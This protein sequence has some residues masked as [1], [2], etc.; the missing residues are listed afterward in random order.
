MCPFLCVPVHINIYMEM[1]YNR[2]NL[3]PNPFFC[4][5]LYLMVA[6]GDLELKKSIN[7]TVHIY[8]LL[9]NNTIVLYLKFEMY[10]TVHIM[11]NG[12]ECYLEYDSFACR[13]HSL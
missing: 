9:Q 6:E 5:M 4:F 3:T 1:G 7:T 13:Q 12:P 2:L 8:Y 11:Q 10:F